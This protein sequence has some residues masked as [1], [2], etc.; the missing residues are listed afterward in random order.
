MCEIVSNFVAFL[1][2]L[3]FT[4]LLTYFGY[5]IDKVFFLL[6]SKSSFVFF[7]IFSLILLENHQ[8]VI[9]KVMT[10]EPPTGRENPNETFLQD[11][12]RTNELP[13]QKQFLPITSNQEIG[14]FTKLKPLD[15]FRQD[16]R[17]NHPR[18]YSALSRYMDVFWSYYPPP[19]AKFHPK[20]N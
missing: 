3:N 17:V 4:Y 15:S 19:P 16:L 7:I 9:G 18:H 8:Y 1:E 14:W 13:T 20:D 6:F 12:R 11:V 2:N 10:A 5:I